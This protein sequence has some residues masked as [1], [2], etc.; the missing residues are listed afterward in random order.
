MAIELQSQSHVVSHKPPDTHRKARNPRLRWIAS[1]HRDAVEVEQSGSKGHHNY[2]FLDNGLVFLL[3][4]RL[5]TTKGKPF[6]VAVFALIVIS[7]GLYLGFT[8]VAC[9][10]LIETDNRK[11]T[12]TYKMS[13]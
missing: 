10:N 13:N 6:N 11:I 2:E 3:G 8:Y 7:G 9:L 1:F 5:V 12:Y 4:G